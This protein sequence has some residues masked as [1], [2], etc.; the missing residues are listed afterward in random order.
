LSRK[1][2]EQMIQMACHRPHVSRDL[3]TRED[4]NLLGISDPAKSKQM[5]DDLN[6][7]LD[8]RLLELVDRI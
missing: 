7:E 6:F 1:H 5:K 8:T 4:F 2:G 3:I